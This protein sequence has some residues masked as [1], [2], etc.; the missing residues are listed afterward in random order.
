[1]QERTIPDLLRLSQNYPNPFNPAT[2]I[3]YEVPRDGLVTLRVFDSVGREITTLVNEVRHAGRHTATFSSSGLGTELAS[4]TYY[5]RV[6]NDGQAL[7]R[8]MILLR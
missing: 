7:T 4:G 2:E 3:A 1:V 6:E 8:K 5:Y